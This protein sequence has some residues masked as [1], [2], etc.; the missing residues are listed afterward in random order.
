MASERRE[1][2]GNS[3]VSAVHRLLVAKPMTVAPAQDRE[4]HPVPRLRCLRLSGWRE[5]IGTWP[6]AR[7]RGSGAGRLTRNAVTRSCAG[8]AASRCTRGRSIG[9]LLPGGRRIVSAGTRWRSCFGRIAGTA[10]LAVGL[11]ASAY[12]VVPHQAGLSASGPLPGLFG[13]LLAGRAGSLRAVA[14]RAAGGRAA[15][16]VHSG[17]RHSH[18]H[19]R[20]GAL[21]GRRVPVS[22][23]LGAVRTLRSEP[24][25]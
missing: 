22:R 10:A 7:R 11:G 8:P 20:R 12:I 23:G 9:W 4:S 6:V 13:R 5:I 18:N 19:A 1:F 3:R 24:L 14:H 15:G 17:H 2:L 25:R 16:S 21:S